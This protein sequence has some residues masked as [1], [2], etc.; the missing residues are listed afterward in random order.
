M[1][2]VWGFAQSKEY[3][4]AF[5]S[6]VVPARCRMPLLWICHQSQKQ[7]MLLR[8]EAQIYDPFVGIAVPQGLVTYLGV[9]ATRGYESPFGFT[10]ELLPRELIPNPIPVTRLVTA[11]AFPQE[12]AT[13]LANSGDL[14]FLE[15]HHWT[16]F[17][18]II[19]QTNPLLAS[20]LV[21]LESWQ[22]RQGYLDRIFEISAQRRCLA[23]EEQEIFSILRA[24]VRAAPDNQDALGYKALQSRRR[25]TLNS[26]FMPD[27]EWEFL[28]KNMVDAWFGYV[29][30]LT[31]QEISQLTDL[32]L[33]FDL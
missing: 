20:S 30:T 29:M 21:T 14:Q 25:V 15:P 31:P 8:E 23:E 3:W 7:E 13:N 22:Q 26:Q 9:L 27:R 12:T 5:F 18:K 11:A 32:N 28:W 16:S 19:T 1:P 24:L 17:K 4:A 6:S 33:T 2:Q 10:V